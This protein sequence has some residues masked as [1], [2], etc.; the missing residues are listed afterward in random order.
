MANGLLNT[1]QMSNGLL[2]T[3][4]AS[5]YLNVNDKSLANSRYTGT[6][7][8]IPYIK[9]GKIVRYRQSDLDDYLENNTFNH[10]GETK[11]KSI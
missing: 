8:Q 5:D 3:Q 1:K 9:M 6:G 11:E 7:M 4:E 10:T 2:D